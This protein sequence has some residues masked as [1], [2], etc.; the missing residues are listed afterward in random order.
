MWSSS[1]RISN[2]EESAMRKVL[3]ALAGGVLAITL[4]AP[5]AHALPAPSPAQQVQLQ[6]NHHDGGDDWGDRGDR[7]D[8]YHRHHHGLVGRLVAD[9]LWWLV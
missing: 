8:H 7:R 2:I 3:G 5:A 6:S 1:R 9:L 4:S